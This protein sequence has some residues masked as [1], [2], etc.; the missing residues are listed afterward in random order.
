M[1]RKTWAYFED[2]M[3]PDDNWLPPD[4]LQEEPGP[5]VAHRTSP[6]NI[7][8]S[9]LAAL[10]AHDLGCLGIEPMLDRLERT[11]ATLD[12]LERHQGH[13]FNWY[14]TQ[15]LVPLLPRYVS[16]VDSGNLAGA[17]TALARGLRDLA[18]DPGAPTPER[19]VALAERAEALVAQMDFRFLYDPKRKLF[20]IG[21]RLGD[22]EGVGSLDGSS[23]DLLASEAR[24]A[25]FLAIAHEDVSQEHWFQLGRPLASVDGAPALLSW[26]ATMFEYLMPRLLMR[27]YAGT[28]LDDSCRLAVRRQMQYGAARGVP[29]GISESAFAV[30]DR[31]GNYQYKPFGVPGLGLKRGLGDD[32]V[33]APYATA[34]AALVEPKE[35]ARNLERLLRLDMEGPYGLYEAIDFTLRKS[36]GG[37]AAV[38]DTQGAR[39]RAYLAHHQGMTLVALANVLCD[40]A[41]VRRFHADP[42]VKATELLLQER[43][44]ERATI[45]EPRPA[46]AALQ[47]SAAR[48]CSATGP[49]DHQGHTT[50]E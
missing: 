16:T 41:M 10:A 22:V 44:P 2:L 20:A 38:L 27:S 18:A 35:A 45:Q 47:A 11:F 25:S 43:V 48:R 28:L 15:T 33:V 36:D 1:G 9:L 3:G 19:S 26:S 24:L 49:R 50:W 34:L 23:Y 46:E 40:D 14:D 37:P 5:K 31:L 7:G 8:L 17:L 39:V 4:N 13:L 32:L 21:F 12:R 30:V 42:R 29:W 6:T